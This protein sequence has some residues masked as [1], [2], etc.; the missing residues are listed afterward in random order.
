MGQENT[1]STISRRSTSAGAP[2]A[3]ASGPRAA[4]PRAPVRRGGVL[5]PPRPP[6]KKRGV[7]PQHPGP[8][9]PWGEEIVSALRSD[10]PPARQPAPRPGARRPLE[11]PHGPR[12]G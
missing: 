12:R 3:A 11:D 7:A 1:A 4:P 10:P 6:D 2:A 9:P 5:W 8:A